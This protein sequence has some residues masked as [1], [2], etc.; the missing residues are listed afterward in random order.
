MSEL[1]KIKQ[2][3]KQN[4]SAL[5][6]QFKVKMLGVFGSYVRGKQKKNSDVDILVEFSQTPGLFDY[7]R[8]ENRLSAILKKRV[9]LVM[10]GSLKPTIG[11]YIMREVVYV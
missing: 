7:V 1:D 4:K 6:R 2:V 8:T 11:K 10:K 9:D 5:K 3:L